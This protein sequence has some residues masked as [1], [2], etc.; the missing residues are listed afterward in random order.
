M[1][2]K[3]VKKNYSNKHIKSWKNTKLQYWQ[4]DYHLT[5]YVID[6]GDLLQIVKHNSI[7]HIQHPLLLYHNQGMNMYK[8]LIQNE[9]VIYEYS[10]LIFEQKHDHN[11][12]HH[13]YTFYQSILRKTKT[14]F[15]TWWLLICKFNPP[16]V[17]YFFV[18]FW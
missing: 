7:H 1:S 3:N 5:S 17:V 9:H 15:T 2:K 11:Q 8:V 13:I 18:Q 12:Q 4:I 16:C 6:N 10:N 14:I